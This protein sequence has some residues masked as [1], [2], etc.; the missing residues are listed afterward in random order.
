MTSRAKRGVPSRIRIVSDA[1][2]LRVAG[3]DPWVK[4]VVLVWLVILAAILVRLVVLPSRPGV[5]PIFVK[6]AR[7][8]L[9]SRNLYIDV[10]EPYRYSPFVTMTF[11]PFSILPEFVGG[12][13][14][15]LLNAGVFMGGLAWWCRTVLPVRLTTRQLAWFFLLVFP[16]SVGSLNNGQSNGLILGLLLMS[17]PAVATERWNLAT[18]CLTI[19][20]LFKLYPIAVALLLTAGYPRRLAVRLAIALA[21]GLG[22]P[23]LLRDPAYALEQYRSWFQH[24]SS[25]DRYNGPVEIAYRD[26]RLLFQLWL[27]PLSARAFLFMQL[28]AASGIAALCL[29]G[30][31]RVAKPRRFL[32]RALVL[33]CCWMTVF[34]PATEPSTY[35]LLGPALAWAVLETWVSSHGVIRRGA[36]LVIYGAFIISQVVLWFPWGM[37]FNN[38][39]GTHPLAGTL[40][41]G[42]LAV[43]S[44]WQMRQ[45]EE[46]GGYG[47]SGRLEPAGISS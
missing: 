31:P 32:T 34:G 35:M 7:N 43:T 20:C 21:V 29:V 47:P 13:L 22:L 15:R 9:A 19:A 16:L 40:L 37:R 3:L 5:Y 17:G 44:L 27:V 36:V 25:D 24:L 38:S 11:V 14:W 6:A 12:V 33:G 42:W 46:S 28:L 39:I 10:G 18:V 45:P 41:L 23:F 8:W 4:F 2:R 1:I 26:I 30:R